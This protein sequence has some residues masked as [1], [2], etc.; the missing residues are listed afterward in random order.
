[1]DGRLTRNDYVVRLALEDER[2]LHQLVG[3]LFALIYKLILVIII[4]MT[5]PFYR[6]VCAIRLK[7]DYCHNKYE[8]REQIRRSEQRLEKFSGGLLSKLIRA[9]IPQRIAEIKPFAL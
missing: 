9:D 6:K 4:H 8:R 2:L 1:M 3:F 7:S 5:R